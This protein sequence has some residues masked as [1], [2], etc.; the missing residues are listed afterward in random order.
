MIL[1]HDDN[2][3]IRGAVSLI[4]SAAASLREIWVPADWAIL[5]TQIAE[6]DQTALLPDT[7][8]T[9]SSTSVRKE[10]ARQIA[11]D[12]IV[13]DGPLS[14]DLLTR[15]DHN[16]RSWDVAAASGAGTW[17]GARNLQEIVNRVRRRAKALI[18]ILTAAITGSIRVRF[19]SI[20]LALSRK[21]KSWETEGQPGTVTLANAAEAPHSLAVRIQPGLPHA[22]ALTRLTVQNRRALCTLL[23]TN[24]RK[25]DG[26]VVIWSDTD[27]N[28]LDHA[29]P[30]GLDKVIQTLSASSA[31]HHASANT[32][33]DRVWTELG[34]AP[35]T[36]IMISAGGSRSQSYRPDYNTLSSR[37]CCTWCRPGSTTYQEVRASSTAAGV[38]LHRTCA[39][40]H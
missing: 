36:L 40:P 28:W 14:I 18:A 35:S 16:L 15:A 17:Y 10:I 6:T 27:G 39:N 7:S 32:A 21:S 25:P 8:V 34:H 20:D 12:D 11:S 1:S 4:T 2:D 24:S 22:Y 26:G 37:R 38:A 5:V 29:G 23:W 3:H 19:F 13:A 30:L 33:H 9:V 31:P